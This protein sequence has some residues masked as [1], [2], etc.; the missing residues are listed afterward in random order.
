MKHATELEAKVKWREVHYIQKQI[1]SHA[2]RTWTTTHAPWWKKLGEMDDDANASEFWQLADNLKYNANNLFPSI[3]EDED[4]ATYRTKLDIMTHIEKYYTDISDNNDKQA[5]E[6]YKSR[7][8][9]DGEIASIASEAKQKARTA[10]S[11]NE[12]REEEEGPCDD[13]ITWDEFCKAL[14]RLKNGRTTGR[15]NIPSEALKHLP[16]VMKEALLHLLN[17]MW[18]KSIT[19]AQWNTAITKLLYKK[20]GRLLIKNYRPITLL[21]SIFKLWEAILET[22]TR[23]VIEGQH[24]SDLQM[25]SRKQNSAAYT[26]MAKKCLVRLAKLTGQT[27]TTLQIDMKKAY[28]RVCRDM[29]WADLYEYGVRGRLLKAIVSTYTSA[30]ET[31]RIGGMTSATFTLPNG[32]RQGS[33]LSPVL[34]ILYTIKLIRALEKTNTGLQRP[35]GGKIPCLMFV[36][37]LATF[38]KNMNEVIKQL[39][40]IN[41]YAVSHKGVVNMFK[42]AVSTTGDKNTLTEAMNASG[43]S[44][45]VV[46][47]YVHLGAKYKLN[48]KRTHLSMSPDVGH[49]LSKGRAML[50]EMTARGLGQTELKQK[51]T[52]HIIDKRVVSTV[53]YGISSLETTATDKMVLNKL[54]ADGVRLACQWDSGETE[55]TDWIILESNLIPPTV[56]TQMNDVTAWIRAAKG[57]MN[58]VIKQLFENDDKLQAHIIKTCSG[59][60]LTIPMLM[61]VKDKELYKT[62]RNAYTRHIRMRDMPNELEL[63]CSK[64]ELGIHLHGTALVRTGVQQEY[65]GTLLELRSILRHSSRIESNV[66]VYCNGQETHTPIHVISRCSFPP[67]KR[68]RQKLIA[69]IPTN[70]G[71]YL[72]NASTPQLAGVLGGPLPDDLTLDER[73]QACVSW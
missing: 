67:T 56:V 65:S 23:T 68:K 35:E 6:F 19:P 16:D 58:P 57:K 64:H 69:M 21:T 13:D 14:D 63:P 44:L 73:K 15:D 52:L 20:G 62:M 45:K 36:D 28:N 29:L 71:Y 60:H 66:C 47:D 59:W 22:R 39:N 46:E 25:G 24:P 31:I 48:I 51:A 41:K 11:Q 43:V 40:A 18:R 9:S 12:Q 1:Q 70:I 54:L 34:Y 7:G 26:I 53:T 33:V 27:F 55:H 38:T 49:R 30:K 17:M 2:S 37:D 61:T 5:Q 4:G 3:M 50:S 32:L 8:M 42:S 10:F 72:T